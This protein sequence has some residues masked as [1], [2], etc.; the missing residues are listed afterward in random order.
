[1]EILRNY[2][3]EL[4][5]DDELVQY[6]AHWQFNNNAREFA[7]LHNN[8]DKGA[9][10]DMANLLVKGLYVDNKMRSDG[11]WQAR[12]KDKNGEMHSV[13][14]KTREEAQQ[15]ALEQMLGVKPPKR[16]K[17][18]KNTLTL[19]EWIEQWYKL[20]K[21]PF[22]RESWA[23][24]I[25][26]NLNKYI[27]PALGDKKIN[28]ITLIDL[29]TLVNSISHKR[30]KMITN[31]LLKSIFEKAMAVPLIRF[32]PAAGLQKIQ[33]EMTPRRPLTEEECKK[34]FKYL[35]DNEPLEFA[36]L[37][38]L[39]IFTGLRRCEALALQPSD[40]NIQNGYIHITKQFNPNGTKVIPLKTKSSERYVPIFA[41]LKKELLKLDF[42]KEFLF[43]FKP[44]YV[45]RQFN[46]ITKKLG[47][48]DIDV[49]CLR[50]TFTYRCEVRGV[51]DETIKRWLGHSKKSNATPNYKHRAEQDEIE[52][53][54]DYLKKFD[55]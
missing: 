8:E 30:A 43:A 23:K 17:S 40:V 48:E 35:E 5:G 27:I 53:I 33:Y 50:H 1:M 31:Q 12:Y 32:N 29:Q 2:F 20:Y 49:H 3:F 46:D 4:H 18:K 6:P 16:R 37:I 13:Y 51:P 55:T 41:E 42:S 45:T 36:I 34:L 28:Q 21:E 24:S 19:K 47:F 39:Y 38:K 54:L 7:V 11:R 44:E 15:K 25:N 22:I 10:A 52:I 9:N 26:Y 14:G